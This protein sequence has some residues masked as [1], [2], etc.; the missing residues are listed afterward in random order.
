MYFHVIVTISKDV[1]FLERVH[2]KI[3]ILALIMEKIHEF[4]FANHLKVEN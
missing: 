3:F 1:I 2:K 4:L